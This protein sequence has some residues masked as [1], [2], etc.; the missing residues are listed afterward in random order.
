MV[1]RPV[2]IIK[3]SN[4]TRSDKKNLKRFVNF[5]WSHYA[6]DIHYVPLLDYEYLGFPLLGIKGFFESDN[7]FFSHAD[8]VWFLAEHNHEIVG[9]CIA[10]INHNHN[11]H[12]HD[13]TGFFYQIS[14]YWK[15]LLC[16][17]VD[18]P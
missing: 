14:F 3:F 18:R 10:F 17:Q 2:N 4:K 15:I 6:E 7:D 5:H 12:W 1:D 9:R 16:L 8:M 13:K 11:R